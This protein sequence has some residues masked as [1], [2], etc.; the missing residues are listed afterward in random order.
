MFSCRIRQ[1]NPGCLV[2]RRRWERVRRCWHVAPRDLVGC[3]RG[4][5][6]RVESALAVDVLV[7]QRVPLTKFRVA[8]AGRRATNP[9]PVA[10]SAP[11]SLVTASTRSSG[12]PARY[13][14][15]MGCALL[16]NTRAR[17]VVSASLPGPAGPISQPPFVSSGARAPTRTQPSGGSGSPGCSSVAGIR[18]ARPAPA[19]PVRSTVSAT[20]VQP[21]GL[22]A[23][24]GGFPTRCASCHLHIIPGP[25]KA[26]DGPRRAN[27]GTA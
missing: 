27:L 2:N 24:P 18:Q 14:R 11:P 20:A 22:R 26:I 4:A 23:A 9:A 7:F 3:M 25:S 21:R 8:E 5:Q 6:R 13:C 15:A 12:H 17:S 19:A 16:A 1:M 10:E